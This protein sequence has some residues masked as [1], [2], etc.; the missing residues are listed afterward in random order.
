MSL[1]AIRIMVVRFEF[2]SV[3]GR[4]KDSERRTIRH[5]MATVQ[6][7]IIDNDRM[8]SEGLTR[9]ESI[10]VITKHT[11]LPETVSGTS[12]VYENVEYNGRSYRVVECREKWRQI[13]HNE[14]ICT[15]RND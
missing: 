14:Y 5:I 2:K 8:L 15:V 11:L 1:N 7:A 6:P 12:R 10:L 9:I 4:A 3:N 13:K